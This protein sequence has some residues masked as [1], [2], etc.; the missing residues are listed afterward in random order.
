VDIA[1]PITSLLKKGTVF[2]WMDECTNALK[3]LLKC[4]QEDPI[5]HRPNYTQPFELE[6]DASQYATGTILLQQDQD[7]RPHAVGYD[8]H[9][10]NQAE[11]NYPVYDRELLALVRGLLCWEHILQSFPFPVEVYTDHNN[12]HYYWSPHHIA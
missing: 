6:V 5:L 10:F 2:H 4:V 9:T 7:N 11:C 1:R 3:T 12:L 8:S